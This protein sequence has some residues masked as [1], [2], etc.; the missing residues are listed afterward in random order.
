MNLFQYLTIGMAVIL[1]T[2]A[3]TFYWYYNSSQSRIEIL[4]AN[5]ARLEL[6]VQMQR[7]TI[8]RQREFL[9]FQQEYS[10][11]LQQGLA[12]AESSRGKLEEIFRSHDLDALSRARPGLIENRINRGT[13]RVFRELESMTEEWYN[14]RIQ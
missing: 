9:E 12:E 7:Q 3:G 4:Q 11:Q 10:R 8:D 5:Q 1:L 14:E 6:S 2:L 13:E